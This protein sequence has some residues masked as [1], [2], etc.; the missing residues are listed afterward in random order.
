MERRFQHE[1]ETLMAA[2]KKFVGQF[3]DSQEELLPMLDNLEQLVRENQH[4]AQ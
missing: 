3:T 2:A 1:Q 4:M